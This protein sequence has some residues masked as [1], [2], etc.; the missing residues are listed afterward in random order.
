MQRRPGLGADDT[1]LAITTPAFDISVLEI[2]LPLIS[3]A[4][5]VIAPGETV[6]DGAALIRPYRAIKRDHPASDASTMR[7]L[8]DA[9]WTGSPHV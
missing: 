7:M 4:R 8:L 2:F 3:G 9:G 1:L 5:V 6:G